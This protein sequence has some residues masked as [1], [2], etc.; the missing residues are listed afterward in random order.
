MFRNT[1]DTPDTPW[2]SLVRDV[3]EGRAM[4]RVASVANFLSTDP[5]IT[6][7]TTQALGWGEFNAHFYRDCG[8]LL[9]AM[10]KRI[11]PGCYAV[12]TDV[13]TIENP[14][15][16]R[17][18]VLFYSD[19]GWLFAIGVF[20]HNRDGSYSYIS[21]TAPPQLNPQVLGFTRR[22]RRGR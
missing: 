18:I 20:C 7:H 22:V 12:A 15:S 3:Y 10:G 19:S 5:F 17:R 21:E 2:Q 14:E 9:E 4:A 6:E 11:R 8:G 1:P 16:N 13:S